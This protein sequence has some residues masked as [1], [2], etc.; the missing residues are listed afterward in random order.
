MLTKE[1]LES[2]EKELKDQFGKC[3]QQLEN[4]TAQFHRIHGALLMTQKLLE[5]WDSAVTV[6]NNG[7]AV[8]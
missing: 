5:Q 1:Y 4:A 8:G 6:E 3:Q 7:V 2:E